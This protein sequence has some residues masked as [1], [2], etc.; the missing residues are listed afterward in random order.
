M[1]KLRVRARLPVV[2]QR[3]P[4]RL[5]AQAAAKGLAKR[6]RRPTEVVTDAFSSRTGTVRVIDARTLRAD[7]FRHW[8]EGRHQLGDEKS[9]LIVLLDVNSGKALL[10]AA[11]HLSSW[12]GGVQ[13]PEEKEVRAARSDEELALGRAALQ[14]V[15]HLR[16]SLR[17]THP[18]VP[19]GIMIGSDRLFLGEGDVYPLQAAREE[20]DEGILFITRLCEEVGLE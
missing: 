2:L 20:F 17:Q 9:P 7:T 8:D 15:L 1:V 13:L 10:A 16:P 18:R 11:P 12:A 5:D 6:L 3:V 4:R 14:R 19:I